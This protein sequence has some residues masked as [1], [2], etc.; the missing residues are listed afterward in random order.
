[1]RQ[2]LV[3]L[4]I[5]IFSS[6]GMAPDAE[7]RRMGGGGSFG[8]KR[9]VTPPKAP[10][11]NLN[12]PNQQQNPAAAQNGK[13]SWMGPIAGLAAGLGLAALFSH[14]GLGE[15]MA[16]FVMLA[17]L[18]FGGFLLFRLLRRKMAPVP[19]QG[20]MQY[21]GQAPG[22]MTP[23]SQPMAMPASTGGSAD[24][25]RAAQFGDFD[26]EAFV[27]QAKVNFIRLQ[28]AHDEGN[29]ADIREFTSP[30][31][32]AEIRLQMAEHGN[33]INQTDVVEL[34]AEVVDVSEE[35]S[36]YVVTVRFSGLIRE[37]QDAAPAPFDEMWHLTK[38][39]DSDR[40]WV[41]AGIQQVV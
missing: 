40:G 4:L 38:A 1:M 17:L 34:N 32:F 33:E 8:M 9:Q 22:G 37:Q 11:Q 29:L 20:R 28:A 36:R 19:A 39:K 27:K 3:F 16:S 31:V 30:E 15:G 5:A 18:I 10:Q 23:P 2:I 14:L 41:I 21:A 25:T 13:R 35:N 26:T 6:V 24:P 12:R 7:A